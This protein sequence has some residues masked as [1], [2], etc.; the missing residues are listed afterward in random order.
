MAGF[1]SRQIQHARRLGFLV[2]HRPHYL[3]GRFAIVRDA[4][5]GL[6]GLKDF[7]VRTSPLRMGD[8]HKPAT[9]TVD[10]ARSG[11]VLATKGAAD[12]LACSRFAGRAAVPLSPCVYATDVSDL[13]DAGG[14]VRRAHP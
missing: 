3:L 7:L 2:A 14:R 12:A 8:L 13:H 10:L 9:S 11:P 1:A 6:N 4:Y 5:S